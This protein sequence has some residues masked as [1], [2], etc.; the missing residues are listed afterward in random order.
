MVFA[1]LVAGGL[2]SIVAPGLG[3]QGAGLLR[4]V[5]GDQATASVESAIFRA[6]DV[7]NGIA[8]R[9]GLE[10]QSTPW[11]AAAATTATAGLASPR[12][13][14]TS[15]IGAV[16]QARTATTTASDPWPPDPV[17]ALGGSPGEGR[18]SPY[19][20]TAAGDVL[21]YRT[22]LRPDLARPYAFVVVVAIDLTRSRLHFVLGTKEPV[23]SV[24]VPRSGRIPAADRATGHLLA[25]FNGGFQARHGHF[26]AMVGGV[27]VLPP[28]PSLGTVALYRGGQVKIGA[29]GSDV[30]SSS[31]LAAWRQNGPL[32]IDRGSVNPHTADTAPQDWGITV[33]GGTTT[34]RSGIGL[35]A[36]GRTLYYAAGQ[37]LTLPALAQA[38][39]DAGVSEGMQLD[40]NRA[41]AHFEAILPG[42]AET[43]APLFDAMPA[44]RRYLSSYT[45]DF[46]YLTAATN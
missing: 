46:F 22:V 13:T 34:S 44:D 9:L 31:G 23:S 43:T 30:V 45:R 39:V 33:G 21:G 38:M 37:S 5:L 10:K 6:Q 14:T 15:T 16:A 40:I 25:T 11:A 2:V 17:P 4:V 29:W 18:W 26:G 8:Y 36:D 12:G 20:T 24:A 1:L 32:I 27:T 3:A 42:K 35:S 41:W 19:L 28:R 7:A